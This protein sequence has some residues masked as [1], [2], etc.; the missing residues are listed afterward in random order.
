MQLKKLKANSTWLLEPTMPKRIVQEV[1][2]L[3]G[4]QERNYQ[5]YA[6][7]YKSGNLVNVSNLGNENYTVR[8]VEIHGI[9]KG[10]TEA[11]LVAEYTAVM[12]AFGSAGAKI[13][14]IFEILGSNA[15]QKKLDCYQDG[16]CA[17]DI[18]VGVKATLS[19][20]YTISLIAVNP[21][22]VVV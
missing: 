1:T 13:T 9:I 19:L 7:S 10:A 2:G 20:A 11:D 12:A 3:I 22:T 16:E 15:A 5:I 6:R 8:H 18:A 17:V 4:S 14:L 21:V